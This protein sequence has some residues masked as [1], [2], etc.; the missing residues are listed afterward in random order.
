VGIDR[1]DASSIDVVLEIDVLSIS[2]T[3]LCCGDD[4][5]SDSKDRC[6]I[7]GSHVQPAMITGAVATWGNAVTKA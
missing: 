4:T 5:I 1:E 3:K 2:A 7:A 6:S